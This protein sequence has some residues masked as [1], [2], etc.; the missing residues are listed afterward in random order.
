MTLTDKEYKI[1]AHTLGVNLEMAA[2]R[3]KYADGVVWNN[4]Y[5]NGFMACV[6]HDDLPLLIALRDKGLMETIGWCYIVTDLGM[7]VFTRQ[8]IKIWKERMQ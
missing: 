1:I 8:F 3:K 7:S 5:R 2:K 4:F 6:G